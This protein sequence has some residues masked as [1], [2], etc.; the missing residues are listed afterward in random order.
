MKA[1]CPRSFQVEALRDGRLG[2]AE[3]A[4]FERHQ[5]GCP[6][7]SA[8]GRVLEVLGAALRADPEPADQLHVR[9]ERVRLLAAYDRSLVEQETAPRAR[10]RIP[11]AVAAAVLCALLVLWGAPRWQQ[12]APPA[13]VVL[14]SE[15]ASWSRVSDGSRE[16]VRLDRGELWIQ[17]A[18]GPGKR[19][20][21]LKLPDGELEDIGTTFSVSV[22]DRRTTRVQ[23]EEGRVLLRLEGR[24]P[25]VLDAGQTWSLSES[26]RDRKAPPARPPEAS[27]PARSDLPPP[28]PPSSERPAPAPA[29][30][31]TAAPREDDASFAFKR[32]VATLNAGQHRQAAA[33]LGRFI[34]EHPADARAEDAAYLRVLAL[35]R[36][37]SPGATRAAAREYL[38]RYPSGFRRIEV[39]RLAE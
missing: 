39:E 21:F 6:V 1:E 14:A 29:S 2:G 12:T 27:K 15:A 36:S 11:V 26:T 17:V 24:S 18:K 28:P 19:P 5:R 4:S 35:Q 13:S 22:E 37:G 38:R 25:M 10:W 16:L 34:Q 31:A 20:L 32:A 33:E 23:V 9:R 8:E 30:A 3:R 7:C